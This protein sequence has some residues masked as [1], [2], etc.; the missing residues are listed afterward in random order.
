MI[1][2][3]APFDRID[4]LPPPDDNER[5]R[6]ER[7]SIKLAALGEMAGGIAHDIRNILAIIDSGLSLA[8][9]NTADPAAS[10]AYLQAAREAVARGARLTSRML[11]FGKRKESDVHSDDLNELLGAL[12]TFVKYG[13]GP[14]IRVEFS[15]AP[16]LPNCFVD[17]PRFN[18]ALLNLVMNARD[19]MPEGGAIRVCTALVDDAPD[20]TGRYVSV[21]VR[22]SGIGMAPEVA[23]RIFDP[24]FTTKG[25]KGT[26]LGLPQVSASMRQVGG[27][28][29]VTSEVGEGALFEL[30]FPVS[31]AAVPQ[32][33]APQAEAPRVVVARHGH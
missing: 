5:V 25:E 22:D 24:Y 14:G 19:A 31:E 23:N 13:A 1:C 20:R 12:E 26:G 29:R 6:S 8:E 17:P 28:V 3:T 27:Y 32:A 10:V 18:A 9:R 7:A 30:L 33:A 16:G 11:A 21:G 15:L 4:A 2:F